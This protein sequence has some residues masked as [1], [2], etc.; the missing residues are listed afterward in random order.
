MAIEAGLMK[1]GGSIATACGKLWLAERKRKA[2]RELGLAELAQARGLGLLPQQRLQ[3]QLKELT[4][5]IAK[6]LSVAVATEFPRLPDNERA[7]AIDA[8]VK[9]LDMADLSDSAL[10]RADMSLD[11]LEE[12]LAEPV[13]VVLAGAHLGPETTAYFE[14]V[15]WEAVAYFAEIIVSLPGF[16]G[17]ALRELL[18]RESTIIDSLREIFDRMPQ[19]S[20]TGERPVTKAEIAYSREIARKLDLVELFGVTSI[21]PKRRL[22]LSVA[23]VGLTVLADRGRGGAMYRLEDADVARSVDE[24]G[25]EAVLSQNPRLLV[26]GE[27]GSGKTTL[28]RWLAVNAARAGFEA[29]LQRWNDLVPFF[30]QLRRYSDKPLPGLQDLN[31]GIGWQVM[32][33]APRGWIGSVLKDGRGLILVDGLDELPES[34]RKHVHDW[35]EDLVAAYPGC[36]YVLTS[37]SP[38]VT[39]DW[40]ENAGFRHAELQAMSPSHVA[41][42]VR[43]WHEAAGVDESEEGRQD[44]EMLRGRLV[45][46]IDA[47]L[48]LKSLATNPLLCA[49]LCALN[50]D[51][52]SSLPTRR[53][54]LYRTALEMLLSKRDSGRDVVD[55]LSEELSV[56]DKLQVLADLAYWYTETGLATAERDRVLYQIELSLRNFS[57]RHLD[58]EDVYRHLL[59]RTGVLREPVVGRVDFLHKTF[60]E[61]LCARRIIE[62][63]LGEKLISK[64]RHEQSYEIIV[65]AV[66]QARPREQN[67]IFTKLLRKVAAAENET[68]RKRLKLLVVRCLETANRLSPDLYEEALDEIREIIPPRTLDEAR[69]LAMSGADAL[70]YLTVS[71]LRPDEAV[72][73]IRTAAL[74]GGTE[75]LELITAIAERYSF[76]SI[77][78]E[79]VSV[80][81]FFEPVEFAQRVF[82]KAPSDAMTLVVDDMTVL[83]GVEVSPFS[84]VVCE[85]A[86]AVKPADLATAANLRTLVGARLSG[87]PAAAD[88]SWLRDCDG[89]VAT[90]SA[91]RCENLR[92]I[93]ALESLPG[94]TRLSL[95]DI[96]PSVDFSR[97]AELKGLVE[98]Q[99]GPTDQVTASHLV[100]SLPDLETLGLSSCIGL[101]SISDLG[102]HG[103]LRRLSLDDCHALTRA[104]D[105]TGLLPRLESLVL[106]ELPQLEDLEGTGGAGHIR[107]LAVRWCDSFASLEG[108]EAFTGLEE[109]SLIE[110]RSLSDLSPLAELKELRRLRL[111]DCRRVRDLSILDRLP[112]LRL[113]DTVGSGV[114]PTPRHLAAYPR[115]RFSDNTRAQ[116]RDDW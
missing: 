11:G 32:A 45:A 67:R 12:A 8:V 81:P 112:R 13:R 106:E 62:S 88:L 66:G 82:K 41:L 23:Y 24:R 40:L 83:P 109:L 103:S 113:L 63:D 114:Q 47:S 6:K 91:T 28:L 69:S 70:R 1:I 37:R 26:R 22:P 64:I 61:F 14:L 89:P 38:A 33:D 44:L 101:A 59:L 102:A 17:R 25:V 79:L 98:L 86:G 7:A 87:C 56:D 60:Q 39:D 68:D 54:E 30:V 35:L 76:A 19:R 46:S 4:E 58:P 27:A 73:S 80:W 10:L 85:F 55:K 92:D 71:D 43:H 21:S 108:I 84:A 105:L 97:L 116:A 18:T 50:R 36:R 99:V 29:P 49:L 95:L 34:R 72:A 100:T 75:A 51:R 57:G 77:G 9:T 74:V 94:L 16:Q 104:G 115:I 31:A 20:D 53:I 5:T 78:D 42:F 52:R 111:R 93:S 15:L 107:S 90:V 48:A 96:A 2:E 3:K 65:M 110:L